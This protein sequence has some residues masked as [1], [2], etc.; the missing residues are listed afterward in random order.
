MF[1]TKSKMKQKT[2]M[3]EIKK[4]KAPTN[5]EKKRWKGKKTC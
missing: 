2:K 5:P 3:L 1:F 4:N